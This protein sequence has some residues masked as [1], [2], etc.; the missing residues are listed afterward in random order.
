MPWRGR[1]GRPAYVERSASTAS[2]AQIRSG[3]GFD[4][5]FICERTS[6]RLLAPENELSE[7]LSWG[8]EI[9]RGDGRSVM[10]CAMHAS[11]Q[12]DF[13]GVW[14]VGVRPIRQ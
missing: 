12:V 7:A 11:D 10:A 1:A 3:D 6:A 4:R 2:R 8:I 9:L 5:S 14:L 13:I